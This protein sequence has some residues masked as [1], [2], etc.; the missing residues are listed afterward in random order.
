MPWID[1]NIILFFSSSFFYG[2]WAHIFLYGIGIL[3][4]HSIHIN[5]IVQMATNQQWYASHA[6][7]YMVV[8]A[9]RYSLSLYIWIEYDSF[10]YEWDKCHPSVSQSCSAYFIYISLAPLHAM[11]DRG[12]SLWILL[13]FFCGDENT[14]AVFVLWSNYIRTDNLKKS[15]RANV[16]PWAPPPLEGPSTI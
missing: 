7:K 12:C 3:K 2:V 16:G 13:I 1:H 11:T 5:Y 4:F 15:K 6:F 8:Y 14:F 10:A 9:F